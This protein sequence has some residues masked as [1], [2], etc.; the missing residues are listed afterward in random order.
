VT[1]P[2]DLNRISVAARKTSQTQPGLTSAEVEVRRQ[3]GLTNAIQIKTSR[4]LRDILIGNVFSP[5]NLVL[6]VIGIGMIIVGDVGSAV[7]TVGLVLINALAS[8]VQEVSVKR[9]LDKIAL[10]T[11]IMVKV[12]RDEHEQVIDPDDI[13][14]G[15]VLIVQAGDQIPVDGELLNGSKIE[16]DE[17]A[18]T[19]ESDLVSKVGGD[20][21][22][23]G[24]ICVTGTGLVKATGVGESS[25]ANKVTK[26]ARQFKIGR[27]PL[28]RD[29]NRLLRLLL[30]I[31]LGL[32]LLVVLSLLF[33]DISLP[34]WLRELSVIASMMSVGL[35]TLLTLNYSWGAVR[36]GQRGALVQQINAVE[37]LSHVT[38]LCCDKTGTLTTN[39]IQYREAY[40]VGMERRALEA[41]LADFVASASTANKT[42]R[43]LIDALHGA[44]R[45]LADEVPFASARKWSGLV[46]DDPPV[47][48]VYVLGAAEMLH[49]QMALTD[50]AQLRIENWANEGF[51]VL[52][53]GRNP[54]VMTLHNAAG[55]PNLPRLALIG[56]LC[57]GDELR[58]H[59]PQ[60][61]AA[62]RHND[63]QIKIISGD[64]PQT[65]VA[66]AR[67]AGFDGDLKVVSGTDLA[68][69]NPGD[70]ASAAAQAT[71]FGRITPQQ[72][73]AL[74]DA[75][76]QQGQF[77]AM[78][79]DGVN[80]VL[81]L[82][83]AD[84]GIAMESGSMAARAVAEI[85]LR[86]DSFEA[87]APALTEGQRT[88]SSIESILKLY[89]VS[90]LALVPLITGTTALGLGFPHTA[91]QG[92]LYSFFARGVPPL[93][94]SVTARPSQHRDNIARGFLRFTFPAI[95]V[96]FVFGL[97]IY[98]GT[99]L[100][101]QNRLLNMAV[102]PQMILELGQRTNYIYDVQTP[103][104]FI[105]TVAMLASQ[106]TLTAFL[107][108]SG[109]LLMLF[110]APSTRWFAVAAPPVDSRL[111]MIAAALL[112]L[113]FIGVLLIPPLSRTFELM[114][115]PPS[116]YAVIALVTIV[117]MIVQREVWRGR[118]LE[119]FLDLSFS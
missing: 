24:S 16:A 23:S 111:P 115:L 67:Q 55:E 1:A 3:Q 105:K 87:M 85:V 14:L 33:I 74:V 13:V 4:S 27:T 75:L 73:E 98:V 88:A 29:V 37:A 5:I 112:V 38:V 114:P 2:P 12:V 21:V 22:L 76:Q 80:D 7:G 18:L 60:T 43:A 44:K 54:D 92:M 106:T 41:L 69:M 97:L 79:G 72:K 25:F 84:V 77:V 62:F 15:D 102:S 8:V 51:R 78:I 34:V 109:I 45:K 20:K 101:V 32:V 89:F 9:Q 95:L 103:A 19:G 40:P 11:R 113:A 46:F 26:N 61:L 68:T 104:A 17:S 57:F 31:I 58:P 49:D 108:L 48:G 71:V 96:M 64:N 66:L 56:I 63:V 6:Y 118:W 82:K 100:A 107:S 86:H 42:A 36:I 94:L 116:V 52:V 47:K 10:L 50:E 35:L 53:F 83:R 119:R 59:L 39:K 110:A 99:Y 90:V 70:F 91:L 117:W 65:V 81:S 93:V 28:E 30:L